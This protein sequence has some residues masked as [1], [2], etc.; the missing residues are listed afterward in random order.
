MNG[1]DFNDM[2]QGAHE[3]AKVRDEL[4]RLQRENADLKNHLENLIATC[5]GMADQQ[6]MPDDSWEPPVQ[7][8]QALIA[9]LDKP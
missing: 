4:A 7:A 1:H 9:R 8:A 2:M 3:E 6:A 5:N